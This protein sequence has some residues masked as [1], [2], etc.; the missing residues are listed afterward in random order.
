MWVKHGKHKRSATFWRL[1]ETM[2]NAGLFAAMKAALLHLLL[3]A[4]LIRAAAAWLD[5]RP[6]AAE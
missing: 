3:A 4:L 6:G 5:A 2:A 1:P